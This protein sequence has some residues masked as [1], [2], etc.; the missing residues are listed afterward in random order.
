MPPWLVICNPIAGRGRVQKQWPAV[1]QALRAAGVDFDLALSSAPLDATRLARDAHGRYRG[2][3]AV[4]GDGTVHEVVNGLLQA[5]GDAAT[6]PLAVVPLGS[7]DDFA[8]VIPPEAPVGGKPHDWREAVEKI[9]RG[10]TRQFDVA[11]MRGWTD[12]AAMSQVGCTRYF[13]NGMDVGFGAQ[14]NSNLSTLPRFLKGQAAYFGA[15]LK[16][17]IDYPVLRLTVQLDDEPSFEFS[18]T[19][20]AVTNGR[21][22][23]GSFW[24]CPQARPDDGWLDVM[25]VQAVGR[26]TILRLIPKITR[27]MH[28]NEPVLRMARARRVLL[29]SSEPFALQADGEMPFGP[30]RRLQVDLLPG[31]L[32]IIV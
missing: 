25:L 3:V 9:R 2:V 16:T 19:M 20:T 13:M 14:A 1:E 22:F 18:T 31:R 4:G 11:V 23:G 17:L 27:G 10:Q 32:T 7:G 6:I 15:V 5:S 26:L 28:G 29:Q 8:K 24:V 30:I 21:C 12:G